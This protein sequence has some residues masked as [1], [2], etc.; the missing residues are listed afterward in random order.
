[1]AWTKEGARMKRR[2][3]SAA[4]ALLLAG[5]GVQAGKNVAPVETPVV[6]VAAPLGFFF[7]AGL[8]GSMFSQD[9]PCAN[10]SRLHDNTYG[11]L[12]QGG[13]DF[14]RYI[15]VMARFLGAPWESDFMKLTH[16]GIYLRPK[17]PVT[18]KLTVYGLLGYGRNKIRHDCPNRPLHYH[19]INAPALGI[20]A[21]Y[22]FNEERIDGKRKG[23]S[24]WGD[25]TNVMYNKAHYDF[26]DTL[27]SAGVNYHF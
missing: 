8:L 16:G 27:I 7:G 6:P 12:V 23:W 15:G 1:M 9:C 24:L 2:V 25:V 22:F 11:G 17:Y 13:Y 21:E 19:W 14:N 26:R 4:A 5:T 10:G 3:L 20:G 18:K